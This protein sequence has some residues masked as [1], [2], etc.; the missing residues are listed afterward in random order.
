MDIEF[1]RV[2]GPMT[3][4][5]LRVSNPK[6]KL[7]IKFFNYIQVEEENLIFG[8]LIWFWVF[9][10]KDYFLSNNAKDTPLLSISPIYTLQF[11]CNLYENF[12]LFLKNFIF[13]Y[14]MTKFEDIFSGAEQTFQNEILKNVYWKTIKNIRLD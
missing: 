3:S 7:I 9:W 8:F 2:D 10:N 4:E 6:F 14:E 11:I 5:V 1:F 12:D 13:L